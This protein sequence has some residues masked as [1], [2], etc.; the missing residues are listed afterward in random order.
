MGFNCHW[1]NLIMNYVTS[2]TYSF[3]VNGRVIDN[4]TPTRGLRHVDPLSPYLFV[5]CAQGL[6]AILEYNSKHISLQ[7]IRVVGV[8]L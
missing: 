4:V 8:V 2:V 6:S 3:N 5:L 1:V 7:G